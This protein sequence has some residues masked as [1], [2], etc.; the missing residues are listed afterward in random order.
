MDDS[1]VYQKINEAWKKTCTLLLGGEIGELNDFSAYLSEYP[2]TIYPL[3]KTKS[4]LSGKD[5]LFPGEPIL[6]FSK[7][8]QFISQEESNKQ[9]I[10]KL[11]VNAIKDIDS[12]VEEIKEVLVFTGNTVFGNTSNLVDST[13]IVDSSFCY[14]CHNIRWS[15]FIAYGSY[16]RQATHVFGS[17]TQMTNFAIRCCTGE[18]NNRV[19][20]QVFSNNCS[21]GYFIWNCWNCNEIMFSFGQ[22][23]KRYMI[24]NREFSRDE[25]LKLKQHLLEQIRDELQKKKSFF[26]F[27]KLLTAEDPSD[28]ATARKVEW[29]EDKEVVDPLN[30]AY[31][32]VQKLCFGKECGSLVEHRDWLLNEVGAAPLKVKGADN[33]ITLLFLDPP[34]PESFKKINAKPF[35]PEKDFFEFH[36]NNQCPSAE[37]IDTLLKWVKDTL[38]VSQETEGGRILKTMDVCWRVDATCA[39]WCGIA[40]RSD[41]VGAGPVFIDSSH[42]FGGRLAIYNSSFVI[43]GTNSTNCKMCFEIDGCVNTSRAYY[44]HNCEGCDDVL[45]CFNLKY[46]RKHVANCE[47]STNEYTKIKKLLVDYITN[48]L[49]EKQKVGLSVYDCASEK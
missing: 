34:L 22:K 19:Y 6:K 43:H 26:S 10:P 31:H 11:D 3:S 18:K 39:A 21:D 40:V 9:S 5:V 49:E 13:T 32:K 33:I 12:L 48:E 27:G 2:F 37:D 14:K 30:K 16:V 15:K 41:Y 20:E 29:N 44:C 8:P 25:Y 28:S 36:K 47:V 7:N 46:K 24:G 4:K 1:L 38:R 42:A 23:N 35:L 45:F 17:L